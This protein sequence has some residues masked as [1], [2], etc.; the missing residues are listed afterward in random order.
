[1]LLGILCKKEN[2][3]IFLYKQTWDKKDEWFVYSYAM[4]L[5]AIR[6]YQIVGSRVIEIDENIKWPNERE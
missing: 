5:V 6:E 3:E 2:G 1:M 4:E